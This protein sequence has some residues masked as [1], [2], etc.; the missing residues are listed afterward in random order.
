MTR[1]GTWTAMA[2]VL[3]LGLALPAAA[4]AGGFATVGLS[5]LP[6][7]TA[8]GRPWDVRITVL[9]HG[10]TPLDDVQPA[11]R[12]TSPRGGSPRTF[13]A[14]PT[15]RPGEYRARVVFPTAGTWTYVV[16]DGFTQTHTFA[17][18]RITAGVAEATPVAAARPHA[19]V[20]AA[21]GGGPDLVL[22]F[23]AALA[24]GL[25]VGALVL[26]VRRRGSAGPAAPARP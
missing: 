22:A 17:P 24:A 1:R 7:G 13:A 8:A 25:L 10:R 2:A 4:S 26:L 18:V 9:Q 5:S 6:D 15:G 11:V 23:G 16:D 12:I 3:A 21:G 19:P 14:R 20:A